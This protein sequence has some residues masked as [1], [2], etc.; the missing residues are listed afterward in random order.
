MSSG[1]AIFLFAAAFDQQVQDLL[2]AECHFDLIE[3]DHRLFFLRPDHH[4]RLL[5]WHGIRQ[6]FAPMTISG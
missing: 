1:P 6:L 3:L 2:I 5:L 4:T